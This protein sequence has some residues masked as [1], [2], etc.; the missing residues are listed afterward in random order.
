MMISDTV[1]QPAQSLKESYSLPTLRLMI[2][3][4][5]AAAAMA[6]QAEKFRLSGSKSALQVT[7]NTHSQCMHLHE[8]SKQRVVVDKQK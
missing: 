3:S 6:F 4:S 5:G 7:H 1:V 2:W 8:Q